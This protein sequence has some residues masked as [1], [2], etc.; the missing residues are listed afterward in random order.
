MLMG[1]DPNG[2]G[3]NRC[4]GSLVIRSVGDLE[5]AVGKPNRTEMGLNNLQDTQK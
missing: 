3:R 2:R 5:F 4:L 1:K